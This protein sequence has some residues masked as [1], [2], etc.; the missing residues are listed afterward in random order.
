MPKSSRAFKLLTKL[1]VVIAAVLQIYIHTYPSLTPEVC[2]WNDNNTNSLANVKTSDIFDVSYAPKNLILHM[3]KAESWKSYF[4]D[5]FKTESS[6]HDRINNPR[7]LLFGDP[8]IKGAWKNTPLLTRLDIF[9]NDYYLGHIFKTMFKRLKPDFSIVMG[10]LVSSQWIPDDEFYNRTERYIKR[11]FPGAIPSNLERVQ[12]VKK[13]NINPEDGINYKA[14]WSS[15]ANE[16]INSI[17][18]TDGHK[19]LD[20]D[21]GVDVYKWNDDD[22]CLFINMT[23][24]HDIGYSG[25]ITYQHLSRFTDMFGTDNFVLHYNQGKK[26]QYRI[27]NLNAMLLEGPGLEKELMD[28]TWEFVYRMFEEKFDGTT[29]LLQHI[30]MYKEK[31]FCEDGPHFSFYP[32]NYEKEL[33]KSNLLKSQNHLSLQTTN[34]LLNLL[35]D[36]GKPGIILT[37]HDHYGCDVVYNRY[38]TKIKD[39]PLGIAES[40]WKASKIPDSQS[41]NSE[42]TGDIV[43]EVT[44]KSMMGDFE[45]ATGLLELSY[46]QKYES[47]DFSYKECVFSVQHVWW[48][49]NIVTLVAVLLLSTRILFL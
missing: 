45:G 30:P 12:N 35:F 38:M 43:K 13:N 37:G 40:Y 1:V 7:F 24:N 9:G 19:P 4:K 33:Y 17:R 27:V 10:D 18:Q 41:E 34:K 47:F 49:A 36:S 42:F 21:F 2:S 20:F 39:H 6:L 3:M 5:L 11:V 44:V 25:D 14:D 48:V 23:G 29:I 32:S 31:G 16:R 15:F 22:S 28:I 26:N 46:N 8:Q